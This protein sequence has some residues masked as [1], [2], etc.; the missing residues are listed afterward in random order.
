MSE[1]TTQA[2]QGFDA[3]EVAEKLVFLLM[4]TAMGAILGAW[5]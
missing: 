1:S 5:Q 3:L 4:L 2:P